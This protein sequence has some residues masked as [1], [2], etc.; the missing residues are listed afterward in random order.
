[1]HPPDGATAKRIVAGLRDWLWRSGGALE[2][3]EIDGY[4]FHAVQELPRGTA[5]RLS[6]P[7]PGGW[8]NVSDVVDTIRQKV[9]RYADLCDR[10]HLP[11]VVVLAAESSAPMSLDLLRGALSGGQSTPFH[12]PPPWGS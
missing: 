11:F 3:T 12:P 9:K 1:M 4:M 8:M 7:D 2:A 10:L 6:E 5:A